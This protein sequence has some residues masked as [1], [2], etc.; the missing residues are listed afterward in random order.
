MVFTFFCLILPFSKKKVYPEKKKKTP[1]FGC[2]S[3]SLFELPCWM[4]YTIFRQIH[5]L[6][7]LWLKY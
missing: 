5:P 2:S 4:I 3:V 7:I 1:K 6:S